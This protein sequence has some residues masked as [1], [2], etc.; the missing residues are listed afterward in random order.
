LNQKENILDNKITEDTEEKDISK[1]IKYK[2]FENKYIS[3]HNNSNNSFSRNLFSQETSHRSNDIIIEDE[4]LY[5]NN[6]DNYIEET[7]SPNCS[8]IYYRSDEIII[9]ED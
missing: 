8:K 5:N 1:K 2:K 3:S 9:T 6:Y 4:D 7:L